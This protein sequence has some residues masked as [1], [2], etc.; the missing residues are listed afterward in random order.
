M[1]EHP[2]GRRR[3]RLGKM[4]FD[5]ISFVDRGMNQHAAVLFWKRDGIPP[6]WEKNLNLLTDDE[7]TELGKAFHLPGQASSAADCPEGWEFD[8]EN[9]R[10][11]RKTGKGSHLDREG[12]TAAERR[13]RLRREARLGPRSRQASQT[14][15]LPSGRQLLQQRLTKRKHYADC[16]CKY[17]VKQWGKE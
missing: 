15:F 11:V 9:R 8:A 4:T 14:G 5:E 6:S 16:T 1:A 10:C 12:E 17:C 3:H 7:L 13:R 2:D